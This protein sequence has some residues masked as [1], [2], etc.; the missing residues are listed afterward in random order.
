ML[1]FVKDLTVK[2]ISTLSKTVLSSLNAYL[3]LMSSAT[4]AQ[5]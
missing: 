2:T 4:I 1:I 3:S 5:T